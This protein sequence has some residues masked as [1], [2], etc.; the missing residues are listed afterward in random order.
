MFGAFLKEILQ[1]A[2]KHGQQHGPDGVELAGQGPV[3]LINLQQLGNENADNCSRQQVDEE[4]P[5]PREAVRD[6]PANR[7][8]ERRRQGASV[9]IKPSTAGILAWLFANMEKPAANTV[10]IMAPPRNP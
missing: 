8:S 9:A 2:E 4:E 10:G 5:S 3:G 1:A 7:R 6:E